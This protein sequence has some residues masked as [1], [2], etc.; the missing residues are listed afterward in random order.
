MFSFSKDIYVS[1]APLIRAC[2]MR[3]KPALHYLT[4]LQAS[5][6]SNYNSWGKKSQRFRSVLS[7]VLCGIHAFCA[8]GAAWTATD[9]FSTISLLF[10]GAVPRFLRQP[11]RHQGPPSAHQLFSW[12]VP[13]FLRQ[14]PLRHQGPPS[15]HQP[16]SWAVRR[17]LRQ[18]PPRHQGPPSA[19]QLFSWAIP[20]FLRQP[21]PRHQ[22]PLSAHQPFSWA[23]RRFLRQPPPRLQ[24]PPSAH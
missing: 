2:P 21:P 18:P 14:P 5:Y 10:S 7:A 24:R 1:P 3:R 8:H 19:H 13:R 15:A 16:F 23:I 6:S 12:A 4:H 17:F 9:N 11:L 20:R 22:R